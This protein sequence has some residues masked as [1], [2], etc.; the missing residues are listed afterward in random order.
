MNPAPPSARIDGLHGQLW[1][2]GRFR[3]GWL[4]WKGGRLVAVRRGKPSAQEAVGLRALGKRKV[5]PGFVDTLLH[6][7][8]GVDCGEGTARELQRMSVA[9]A[10][11]GVTTAYAGFYPLD[12]AGFRRAGAR[13]Q[14]WKA[15]RGAA[16]TRFVGWHLEG[17][18]LP[19]SM[20]GALPAEALQIP[21]AVAATRLVQACRGWLKLCMLAPE[22][23]GMEGAVDV[24]RAA[25]VL[26]MI[27]HTAATHL[28]CQA[29]AATGA[30]GM[31]HLG[32]R[33]PPFTAREAGPIGFAMAG[34]AEWV[35]VIP[36]RVH[37]ASETLQ[38]WASTPALAPRLMAL[39]DNLS[40]AG[41]AAESFVAGGQTLHRSASVALDQQGGLSG[42]LDP[43]PELLLRAVR[44]GELDWAQA[45]SMGAEVPG[46]LVGDCGRLEE[47]LRAD[48]LLLDDSGQ[49]VAQAWVGGRPAVSAEEPA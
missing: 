12:N 6:G 22:L 11:T 32:N 16:R 45:L 14:A 41:L 24:L 37:V 39:S 13:W 23:A 46:R 19:E 3:N 26:P 48:V 43:L 36:D 40:H 1:L 49:H 47:G 21:S 28:D 31:T 18:F 29:V 25:G 44:D 10:G 27:G 33:M 35:G 4:R 30:V 42:T 38:L 2:D 5:L 7:F 20:R 8:A 34:L 17:P 9:L 15:V